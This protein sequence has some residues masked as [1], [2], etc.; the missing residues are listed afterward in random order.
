LGK[1][2]AVSFEEEHIKVVKAVLRGG[3]AHIEQTEIVEYHELDSYLEREKATE[4]IVTYDFKE[5]F[6]GTLRVPVVKSRYQ[7][8][9][10]ESE[11][12][13]TTKQ[14]SLS[15][16]YMPLGERVDSGRK[17]LEVF[18]FAVNNEV[19]HDVVGRFY[20]YGKTVKAVYPTVFSAAALIQSG[21]SDEVQMGIFSTGMEKIV[22]FVK[23]GEVHFIRNFESMDD[24]LSDFDIQNI[25][26]TISYCFQNFRQNPSSLVLI[27]DLSASEG[28]HAFPT[29][30]VAAPLM[31]PEIHC[32]EDEFNRFFLPIA[33]LFAPRSSNVLS[34]YFRNVNLMK[35]SMSAAAAMF[36]AT[37]VVAGGLIFNEIGSIYKTKSMMEELRPDRNEVQ[38]VYSSYL[39]KQGEFENVMPLIGFLNGKHSDISGLLVRMGE[40][41]NSDMKFS[42]VDASMMEGGAYSVTITGQ[43]DSEDYSGLQ[44]SFRKLVA[45]L[46]RIKDIRIKGT[47]LNLAGKS[48]R[49]ELEYGGA[50]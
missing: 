49:I 46:A 27:G 11:L 21:D 23:R 2:V 30:P 3:H 50:G 24:K 39:E 25:N 14:E 44:E 31:P 12:R 36:M 43:G 32:N 18:Y 5:A 40:I 45:D 6:H 20:D 42:S 28:F 7:R 16:I 35:L 1:K 41:S 8:N 13:K 48:F 22:F 29:V 37:V 9:L 33:S 4:F 47:T 17:S 15:F 10:I 19:I 34:R 38:T 26:M